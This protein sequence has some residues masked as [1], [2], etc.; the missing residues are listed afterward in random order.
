MLK[1]LEFLFV[2]HL[3]HENRSNIKEKA[4]TRC[5]SMSLSFYYFLEEV[6]CKIEILLL[7]YSKYNY[8]RIQNFLT[9]L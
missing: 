8:S 3:V 4:Q 7:E 6:L 9:L 2:E 1:N 5:N